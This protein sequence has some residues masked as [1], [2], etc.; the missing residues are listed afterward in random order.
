MKTE[1]SGIIVAGGQSRRMGTNMA[2][3][4]LEGRPLIQHVLDVL[5]ELS[6][7]LVIVTNTPEQYA[8]FGVRLVG[9]VIPGRGVLCGIYS[10]LLAVQNLYSFVVGCDMPFLNIELLRRMAELTPGCDAVVPWLDSGPEPSSAETAKAQGTHPLHAIYSKDC[11]SAMRQSLV[12]GDVRAMAFFAD[13]RVCYLKSD[14]I[15]R[16]DPSRRS[17][18]NLNTPSDL[19]LARGLLDGR[20]ARNSP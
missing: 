4:E 12:K 3:I 16:I 19:V 15:D 13:I 1:L 2:L 11:L 17:L 14:E 6:D 18:M 20:P 9:D 7:D 8:S 10:G 5:K